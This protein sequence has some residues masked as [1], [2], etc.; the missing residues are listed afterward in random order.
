[1]KQ[2]LH[3]LIQKPYD[4]ETFI[5]L[6]LNFRSSDGSSVLRVPEDLV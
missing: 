2:I 1:M 6:I 4:Y 5:N 3:L